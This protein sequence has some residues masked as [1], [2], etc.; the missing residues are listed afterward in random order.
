MS[1]SLLIPAM[2]VILW[3]EEV[4]EPYAAVTFSSFLPDLML[5]GNVNRNGS[6]LTKKPNKAQV[7]GYSRYTEYILFYS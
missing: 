6:F 1:C 7:A 2:H 5:A 4:K 3:K